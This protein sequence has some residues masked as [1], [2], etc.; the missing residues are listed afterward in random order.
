MIQRQSVL[1]T[2]WLVSTVVFTVAGV[3]VGFFMEG[4]LDDATMEAVVVAILLIVAVSETFL[5]RFVLLP[6]S[7]RHPEATRE[8]AESLGYA[9]AHASAVYGT[10]ASIMTGQGLLAL[11]FGAIAAVSWLVVHSYLEE[12]LG[13]RQA[14]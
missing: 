2:L 6:S 7:V 4:T 10:V 12:A 11:P 5:V 14:A 13:D 1:P 9:F 3:V 8:Q